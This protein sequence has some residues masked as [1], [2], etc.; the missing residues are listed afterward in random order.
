[1]GVVTTVI[2][3]YEFTCD[4]CGFSR[5]CTSGE[6]IKTLN[7]ALKKCNMHKIEENQVLC[8]SCYT[9]SK[10]EGE[11]VVCSNRDKKWCPYGEENTFCDYHEPRPKQFGE[12]I[13]FSCR[14]GTSADYKLYDCH[15]VLYKGDE[16]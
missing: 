5:G 4:R 11:L 7:D 13:E 16:K 8:H 1:M 14:S 6:K 15:L 10:Y 2:K 3:E 9:K 12:S